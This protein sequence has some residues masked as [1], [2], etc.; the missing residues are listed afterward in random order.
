MNVVIQVVHF[1]VNGFCAAV[2]EAGTNRV[3]YVTLR[4]QSEAEAIEEADAFCALE[5]HTVL[6]EEHT[7]KVIPLERPA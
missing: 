2:W 6:L 3:L 1:K 4:H 7:F 5:Q